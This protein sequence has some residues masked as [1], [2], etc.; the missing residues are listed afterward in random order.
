MRRWV[1]GGATSALALALL[2]AALAPPAG[3]ASAGPPA[4]VGLA[5]GWELALD[6]GDQGIA[7]GRPGGGGASWRPTT[8]PGVLDGRITDAA[9]DG[10][11]GW[12][13]TTFAGP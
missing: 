4:P 7:E 8:V 10:T 5:S 3:A 9:F 11:V 1:Q 13:R 12:Y 6:P 2:A